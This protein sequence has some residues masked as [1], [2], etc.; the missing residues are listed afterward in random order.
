MSYIPSR[1]ADFVVWTGNLIAVC[2]AHIAMWNLPEDK[3]DEMDVLYLRVKDLHDLSKSAFFTKADMHEKNE[4]KHALFLLIEE[5][6]RNCLQN[7]YIMTDAGRTELGIPIHDR[8]LTPQ[9]QP[10]TK[11][12]VQVV[13]AV[14]RELYFRFRDQSASRWGK[15]KYVSRFELLWIEGDVKPEHIS[16]LIHSAFSTSS[17]LKMVFDENDRGKKIHFASRWENSR[18]EKGPCTEIETAIVP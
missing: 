13:T 10:K 12:L 6:V 17:P 18:G 3:L 1:E 9:P 8:H 11:P 2:K 14:I 7:N 16:E 15:P 5:F 4:K